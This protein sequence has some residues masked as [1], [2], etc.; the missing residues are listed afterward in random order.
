MTAQSKI[1]SDNDHTEQLVIV[2]P[3][4]LEELDRV[5]LMSEDE[6]R[7]QIRKAEKAFPVWRD[8]PIEERARYILKARDYL[9]EHVDEISLTVT[10]EMGK[11]RVESLVSEI[12]VAADLMGYYAKQ[13]PEILADHEIPIHLF[14]VV[15][16]S[17]IRYEPLGVVSVISPS[18]YPLSIHMGSIV[19]ALLAGNTVVFKAASDAVLI[20]K[21]IEEIF[22]KGA[23]LPQGVL[24]LVVASG[25]QLGSLLYEPPIRK[26]AFTGSTATG[27]KI[28]QEAAKH[29]IPTVLELGGKDA[30]IVLPDADLERAAAGAVWG[31]FSNTGQTCAG[32]ERCYVHRS[33]YSRFV[34]RVQELT[35]KL[36]VG[37]GADPDIDIGPLVNEAQ[38]RTVE[39]HVQD[40]REKGAYIL[41]GGKRPS[42]LD[43]YFYEPTIL[44]DVD[45]S[46]KCTTEETFGPLLPVM[47]FD[48]EDEVVGFANDSDFGLT[49]SI[50]T[51][52][53]ARGERLAQ[54]LEVGTVSIN[55][56]VSSFALPETP[57]HGAKKSGVGVTHSDEGLREFAFPK[58]ITIDRIPLT[59]SP[60][61]Y[62]YSGAKYE[63]FKSGIRLVLGDKGADSVF[64]GLK[65]AL[66]AFERGSDLNTKAWQTIRKSLNT[67]NG[68]CVEEQPPE[69]LWQS[70]LWAS[71]PCEVQDSSSQQ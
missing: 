53:R 35:E 67:K 15:R 30:M 40:A 55:D 54:R 58:H 46:M 61:W 49:A 24:N 34:R 70:I 28:A 18:N 26:V 21:K 50:W 38:L 13:A 36:R 71:S 14:K 22:A 43:G 39:S 57:W 52:D 3:A 48:T 8:I 19:F 4:T 47:P 17:Y 11:P 25:S 62:P 23:C 33:V 29:L 32:V 12:L 9:L 41:S 16:Q 27:T 60:W 5:S 68:E 2:D 69:T 66:S 31:A 45:H 1:K 56:H 20:A 6:V 59:S 42:D 7:E 10:R 44:V 64:N 65:S 63:A 51:K 37:H